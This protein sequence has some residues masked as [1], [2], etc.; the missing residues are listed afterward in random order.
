MTTCVSLKHLV[1][2][3]YKH[4]HQD[5]LGDGVQ[6]RGLGPQ[7]AGGRLATAPQVPLNFRLDGALKGHTS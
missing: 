1:H 4:L 3:F 5:P 2:D 7:R 6:R